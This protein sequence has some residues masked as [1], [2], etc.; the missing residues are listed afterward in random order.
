MG[1]AQA[2]RDTHENA[3]DSAAIL[4]AAGI[5]R[6]ILVAHSFDMP[7]AKAEF[8]A[9]GLDVTPAPTGIP[10]GTRDSWLE[11]LPSVSAL[12]GSYYALYEL[13]ANAVRRIRSTMVKGG[14]N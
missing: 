8:S 3:V 4:K 1:E 14:A 9:A 10:G 2:I 13:L 5:R 7:R 11:L 12:Q 6:V